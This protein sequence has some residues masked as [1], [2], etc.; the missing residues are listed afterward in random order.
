MLKVGGTLTYALK[1]S[2][3]LPR[4]VHKPCRQADIKRRRKLV[5][6]KHEQDYRDSL[7]EQKEEVYQVEGPD[8]REEMMDQLR[9]WCANSG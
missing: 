9:D 5:Q 8:M 3:F 6:A 7:V 4:N 2:S 1:L